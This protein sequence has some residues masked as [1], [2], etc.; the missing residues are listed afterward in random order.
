VAQFL[1]HRV[2]QGITIVFL[3]ATLTFLLIHL[4]PGDPV[5]ALSET[6][7]RTPEVEQQLRRN[8]G[9]DRPLV[10]QYVRYILG[11]ARGDLGMSF[12]ERRPVWSAIRERIPATMGLAL[13]ALAI[14]FALGISIGALQG[15]RAKSRT[16][17]ALSLVTLTLFSVP[18]FWLGLMLLL[19][20][21]QHLGWFP[22]NGAKDAALYPY[23]SL[24]GKL[25]DRARHLVLPALTLG[26]VG[27]ATTARYQRAAMLEV[28]RHDFMRTARSKGL[29]ERVVLVRHALRNA[30]LPTITL[31]GLSLPVLLSGAVLV[32]SVFG[33][34][35]LGKFAADAIA[36]RDY[37]VVTGAAIAA[38]TMVVV[39]NLLADVLY[40]VVDPR[41]RAAP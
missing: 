40:R 9:L 6:R 10:E 34:P 14:D 4:A 1:T 22:V 29:T 31:F 28:M 23:L 36:A 27:A 8:L 24:G 17:D 19:V 5:T 35:G 41:T 30:L 7:R 16:D 39:G 20:F 15:A 38:A 25:W 12:A 18:V 32:E 33:W 26:L 13:A 11:V 37:P 3:V 21:A 2:L